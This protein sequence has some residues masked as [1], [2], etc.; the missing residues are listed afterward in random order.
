MLFMRKNKKQV[1]LGIEF[2]TSHHPEYLKIKK[3]LRSTDC[4]KIE[5]CSHCY[6]RF[7]ILICNHA[8]EVRQ[9][10][11]NVVVEVAPRDL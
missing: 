4:E 10:E 3:Y 9:Y 11:Y 7:V 2:L 1:S 6:K 8:A 5:G